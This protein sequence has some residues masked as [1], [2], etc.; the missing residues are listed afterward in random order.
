MFTNGEQFSLTSTYLTDALT[1]C[2]RKLAQSLIGDVIELEADGEVSHAVHPVKVLPE[3]GEERHSAS[4]A[5]LGQAGHDEVRRVGLRDTAALDYGKVG[6]VVGALR[7]GIPPLE[8]LRSRSEHGQSVASGQFRAE[9]IV[10]V[11]GTRVVC[12]A[13]H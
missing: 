3:L 13:P 5:G 10:K 8:S 1:I 11:G 2:S 4:C 12:S 7:S 6:L 9:H